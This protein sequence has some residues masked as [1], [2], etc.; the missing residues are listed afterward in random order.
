MDAKEQREIQLR[1]IPRRHRYLKG[2]D[3]HTHVDTCL[4]WELTE[5]KSTYLFLHHSGLPYVFIQY[6]RG[7]GPGDWELISRTQAAELFRR[8]PVKF[9]SPLL[10][11]EAGAR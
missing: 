6:A 8:L 5:E 9:V 11:V 1:E 3:V 2:L 4:A 10:S 7:A